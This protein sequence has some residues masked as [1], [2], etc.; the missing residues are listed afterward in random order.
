MET[1][2][3][4]SAVTTALTLYVLKE[5]DTQAQIGLSVAV[6]VGTYYAMSQTPEENRSTRHVDIDPTT[7]CSYQDVQHSGEI[8]VCV[9]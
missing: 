8:Y 5:Q 2:L 1:P 7:N 9:M 3:I 4:A 6:G